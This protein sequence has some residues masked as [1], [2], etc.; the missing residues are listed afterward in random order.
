[1]MSFSEALVTFVSDQVTYIT[2]NV[3]HRVRTLTKILDL[4]VFFHQV[5]KPFPPGHSKQSAELQKLAKTKLE[6]LDKETRG[7]LQNKQN[8]NNG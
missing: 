1:M 6:I 4:L 8:K 7:S 5:C 3:K 2:T